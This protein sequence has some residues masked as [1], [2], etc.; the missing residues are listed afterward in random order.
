MGSER[1]LRII[2]GHELGIYSSGEIADKSSFMYPAYRQAKAALSEI[3]DQTKRFHSATQN[4]TEAEFTNHLFQY[5]S[6]I[7]AFEAQRGGGKT[8]TMLSFSG[9]LSKEYTINDGIPVLGENEEYSLNS[10]SFFTISPISPSALEGE[11]NILYVVLSRLYNY[12]EALLRPGKIGGRISEGE[13]IELSRLLHKCL[14]GINGIK[15]PDGRAFEDISVLQD[16]SDGISLRRH[17]FELIQCIIRIANSGQGKNYSFLVLQLDDADSQMKNGYEV[18]EDVRKYLVIPNLVILMS[19]DLDFLHKV[20]FQ[21][22][23]RNF[24]DLKNVLKEGHFEQELSRMCRKYIDK[25]IPP[26]HMIH[27]PQIDD[28]IERNASGIQL[29]YIDQESRKSVFS[30]QNGAGWNVQNMLLMLIYRKTGVLFVAPSQYLHNIIPRTLRGLNQLVYLLKNMKDIQII[31]EA[32][33]DNPVLLSEKILNQVERAEENLTTFINYFVHDWLGV[34]IRNLEDSV[35]LKEFSRTANSNRIRL[36]VQYLRKKFNDIVE[37]YDNIYLSKWDENTRIYLDVLMAVLEQHN[38]KQEDF[39]LFFSI[40]TILTLESHR[41]ILRKKR[42][43]TQE[44]LNN[45]DNPSTGS[46]LAFDFDPDI[47]YVPHTYIFKRDSKES[48]LDLFNIEQFFMR[49]YT[50]NDV[51]NNITQKENKQRTDAYDLIFQCMSV[52]G[53]N[54]DYY[55]NF[56][57]FITLLLKMGNNKVYP[58]M[59]PGKTDVESR[60]TVQRRIYKMQESA[61]LIA[62]NWDVQARIYRYFYDTIALI[63]VDRAKSKLGEPTVGECLALLY[64]AVDTIIAGI[65]GNKFLS[66]IAEIYGKKSSNFLSDITKLHKLWIEDAFADFQNTSAIPEIFPTVDR[67]EYFINDLFDISNN[68]GNNPLTNTSGAQ[69]ITS[70]EGALDTGEHL[71]DD[72]VDEDTKPKGKKKRK[73]ST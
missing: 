20:I 63:S 11:Q 7:I 35:F 56:L 60:Q 51:Q 21:D 34:K 25:L 24:K 27:L 5:G 36:A 62:A 45:N 49:E 13:R 55:I 61:L 23:L 3:V 30:W 70:V 48:S 69:Q 2:E 46:F 10:L 40:H 54:E 4:A 38:R 73:K 72:A 26:S 14:S 28:C 44:Y 65:N 6:N 9:I 43:T 8:C 53:A 52:K 68:V 59:D 12:A 17:F 67:E 57:N 32:D 71:E 42:E 16:I 41:M 47:I 22:H 37:K 66:I 58:A 29:E 33:C 19:M 50:K 39:L 15:R 1:I 64:K 31:K 18:L